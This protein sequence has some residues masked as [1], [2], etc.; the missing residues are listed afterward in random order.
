MNTRKPD[1]A[2]A[3]ILLCCFLAI[4]SIPF[5]VWAIWWGPCARPVMEMPGWCLLLMGKQ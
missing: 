3:L 2:W 1:L 5:R 4:A